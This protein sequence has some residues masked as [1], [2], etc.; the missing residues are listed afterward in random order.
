MRP[1]RKLA[2]P[3][4][5]PRLF[6]AA[7][8][9]LVLAALLAL[10]SCAGSGGGKKAAMP[11]ARPAAAATTAAT[12]AK[13]VQWQHEW[14]RGAVFY[15]VFVR[16]FADSDG[17][18]KGDLKGLIAKL[19]YLNTGDP[20]STGDLKVDALWL[21][22]V[23]VSPSYHGYDTTDYEHINPDY[24]T[25]ADFATLCREAHRR[26]IR[27]IVDLVVNHTGS[28]H[29]WFLES[30]S[31]LTSPKRDWYVWRAD[32]PGWTQPW[33]GSY[34][35]WHEKGGMYFYGV[36][37]AGMPD[38]NLRNPAVRTEIERI[39][40]LWLER[41]ADGF[42][43]DAAR[44]LVE[45]GPGQLQVDQPETHAFWREFAATVRSAR[46]DAVLVG[47]NWT[48][49]DTIATYYG[50]TASV[51][52]G[53]ELPMNFDFPLAD[54]IV[55]GVK[56]GDGSLI[57]AKLAEI[58]RSYPAGVIDT[59][60]LTNHDQVRLATQL[61]TDRGREA[62]AAAVLLTLPGAPFLYYGEEVGLRNGGPGGD[63]RLKRTPMPW[64]GSERGGFTTATPWFPFAPGQQTDN[65]AVESGDPASLLARYR[66]LIR[67]RH[68]SAALRTGDLEL[69][70]SLT[71]PSPVLAFVRAVKG[72][73]VLVAHNL[74]DATAIGGPY[75]VS[76][77][78]VE[79]TVFADAD[80][81]PP[82]VAARAWTVTLPPHA[83]GIWRLH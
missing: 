4:V 15:E 72:E 38:L 80:A 52:G 9:P 47:E 39:A 21:M 78:A 51:A 26:G 1:G 44:H 40:G 34:P 16:S 7:Y 57:A 60:F 48:D 23:F 5:R 66:A 18:G 27:I 24:G 12:A 13:A 64:D 68:A 49:T 46:P 76:A 56:A 22:P 17:D 19:D 37:W 31:S 11:P 69:L 42:R 77:S 73:K 63:D 59:P 58:Q 3:S 8:P 79:A 29:P 65:V 81:A 33:G 61:G 55:R 50:S 83:T 45:N 20:S 43:L 32:D 25:D 28:A 53:D 70:G 82:A 14:A 30:S 10:A 71:Q 75:A 74:G 41:G 2:R 36:F 54:A 62:S 67:A 35:T 6:A